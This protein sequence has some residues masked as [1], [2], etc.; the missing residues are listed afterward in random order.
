MVSR[1]TLAW[2]VPP[3]PTLAKRG[4][5]RYRAGDNS[6]DDFEDRLATHGVHFDEWDGTGR[7]PR[8]S[9][10]DGPTGPG[11]TL[12]RGRVRNR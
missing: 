3:C 1:E 6:D 4:S 10:G 11:V 5:Y 9:L 7:A 8:R 2:A 12:L